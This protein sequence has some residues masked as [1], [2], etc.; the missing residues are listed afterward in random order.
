MVGVPAVTAA[1]EDAF[2]FNTQDTQVWVVKGAWRQRRDAIDFTNAAMWN[3][4]TFSVA[5]LITRNR[6]RGGRLW[7]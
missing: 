2:M 7:S 6:S 5:Q 3:V 1:S 4:K